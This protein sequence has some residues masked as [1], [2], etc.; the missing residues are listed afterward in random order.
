MV[1][2]AVEPELLLHIG[3]GLNGGV[4]HH[5]C[6]VALVILH[7]HRTLEHG[8]KLLGLLDLNLS[9]HMLLTEDLGKLIPSDDCLV[10]VGVMAVVL[11]RLGRS[12]KLLQG[13]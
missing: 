2:A 6:E 7:P 3:D 13:K 9:G 4:P 5:F 8:T 10:G 11:P 1:K 12:L